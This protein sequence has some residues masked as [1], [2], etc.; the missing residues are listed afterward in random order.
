MIRKRIGAVLVTAGLTSLVT[1]TLGHFTALGDYQNAQAREGETFDLELAVELVTW[2]SFSNEAERRVANVEGKGK[3]VVTT[4]YELVTAR[5]THGEATPP[6][7][8]GSAIGC[9]RE[10]ARSIRRSPISEFRRQ[11][12]AGATLCC[13]ASHLMC[14]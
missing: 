5:F 13:V 12:C 3:S 7:T 4:L 10:W 2:P 14:C 8:I 1:A 11:C 6:T 9:W